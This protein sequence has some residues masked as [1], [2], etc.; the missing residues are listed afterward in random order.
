M[1]E[2]TRDRLAQAEHDLAKYDILLDAFFHGA[3]ITNGNTIVMS[4]YAVERFHEISEHCY[5]NGKEGI[6]TAL[7]LLEGK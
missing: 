5:R 7:D 2:T 4:R 1:T 3:P 6:R